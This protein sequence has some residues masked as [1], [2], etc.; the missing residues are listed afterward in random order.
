[1]SGE[2]VA[3][4]PAG[5]LALARLLGQFSDSTALRDL[6]VSLVSPLDEIDTA[7]LDV[8]YRRWLDVGTEGV[9]LDVLGRIVGEP[10]NGLSDTL[11]LRA[12]RTRVLIN[13][14]SGR[15]EQLLNIATTFEPNIEPLEIREHVPNALTVWATE[16]TLDA[17][18]RALAD[19]LQTARA[20][21]VSLQLIYLPLENP[22]ISHTFSDTTSVIVSASQGLGSTTET[23]GG[24]LAGVVG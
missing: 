16:G 12:L 11:Y 9:Q 1:V 2:L 18:P 3:L 5:D 14:S 8:H 22:A 23:T 17:G 24:E 13:R 10:R 20:G 15:L 19:R 4:A 7:L 21:G 6:I